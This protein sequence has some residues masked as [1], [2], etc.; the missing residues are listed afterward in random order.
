MHI[1]T[2]SGTDIHLTSQEM[3]ELNIT[4]VPLNV[5]LDDQTYREG[6]DIEVEAFYDLLDAS[7]NMPTTSQPS[8]GDFAET[9]RQL[10]KT[11]V[12]R[13]TYWTPY[14]V[15]KA[16]EYFHRRLLGRPTYVRHEMNR[17]F[18]IASKTGLYGLVDALIDSP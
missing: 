3:D 16:I 5:T 2:D 13:N 6:I 9:Y 15:V 17:Y 1:V 4:V 8:A 11:D 14:Y 10:A 18:D 7:E 12:F